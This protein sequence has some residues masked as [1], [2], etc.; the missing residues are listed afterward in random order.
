[1]KPFL[2]K[3]QSVLQLRERNQAEA[4]QHHAAAGRRLEAIL[5]ELAEAE[6]E[7]KSLTQQ[8]QEMQGSTFR[9]AEREMLW[10]ALKYQKDL[11]GRL[12]QKSEI[13][14]KD[15][16]EKREKLLA[17]QSEHEAMVKLREKDELEY[18]RTAEQ[19]E[20]AMVDDLVNAQHSAK[21]RTG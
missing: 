3:L 8:L 13:A 1:M 17:A 6:A 19:A 2:F 18:N 5:A 16:E 9:P 12:Q 15:L 20:R 14:A 7:H 11:C 10:N 4:Q 21:K